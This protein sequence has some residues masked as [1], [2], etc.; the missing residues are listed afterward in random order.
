M[1]LLGCLQRLARAGDVDAHA[2]VVSDWVV[3]VDTADAVLIHAGEDVP[4]VVGEEA[5]AVQRVCEHLRN[6]VHLWEGSAMSP[7]GRA[8]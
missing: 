1:W 7:V 4:R 8:P 2:L 5:A 6:R 3:R